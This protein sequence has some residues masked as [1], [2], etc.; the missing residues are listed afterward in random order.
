MKPQT[1]LT[2]LATIAV[3]YLWIVVMVCKFTNPGLTE[4]QIFLRIPRSLMLDF[5]EE[6]YE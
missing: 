3:F 6:K 5:T 2:I 4:T 1:V